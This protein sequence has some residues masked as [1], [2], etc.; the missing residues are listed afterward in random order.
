MSKIVTQKK[1]RFFYGLPTNTASIRILPSR[2]KQYVSRGSSAKFGDQLVSSWGTALRHVFSSTLGVC[3]HK[4]RRVY[5]RVALL[6]C[7]GHAPVVPG[8][9]A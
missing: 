8:R 6:C 9:N 2:V 4:G 5:R 7:G 1:R 3:V